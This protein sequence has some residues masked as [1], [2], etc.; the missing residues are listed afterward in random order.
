MTRS[1]GFSIK[2]LP[3]SFL[4]SLKSLLKKFFLLM[5]SLMSWE[6][7]FF[8]LNEDSFFHDLSDRFLKHLCLAHLHI[9]EKILPAQ[10]LK[11]ARHNL[12]KDQ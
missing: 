12:R 3:K 9:E 10:D 4:N 6:K 1:T 11:R 2:S 8:F 7:Y 5:T